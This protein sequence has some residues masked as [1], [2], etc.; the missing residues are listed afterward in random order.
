MQSIKNMVKSMKKKKMIKTAKTLSFGIALGTAAGMVTALLL[1]PRP[2]PAST[3]LDQV[4]EHVSGAMD[5]GKA[6]I[7]KLVK[8]SKRKLKKHKNDLKGKHDR[9]EAIK[10][11]IKQ[12]MNK[13]Q[14]TH[15]S[16]KKDLGL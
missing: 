15:K 2:K 14:D 3:S 4:K 7:G 12:S 6:K 9:I 10:T 1:T 16:I 13:L 11:D 5:S 8:L